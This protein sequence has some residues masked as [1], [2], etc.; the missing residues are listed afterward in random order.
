MKAVILVA[1]RGSRMQKATD[2]LPKC[3][4]PLL[5][6]P[7]LEWQLASLRAAGITET[8]GITGYRKER[9][10]SYF[11]IVFHNADWEKTNMLHTLLQADTLLEKEDV[12]ICYGDI[13]YHPDIICMLMKSPASLSITYDREWHALWKLRFDDVL[14]DAETFSE[15][16]GI[17]QKIGEKPECIKEI[18]GQYMG[19]IK[20]TP[21]GWSDLKPLI[22]E[23]ISFTAALK[24]LSESGAC[25][26]ALPISGKWCEVDSQKDLEQYEKQLL[27]PDRWSHDF[28]W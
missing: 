5:G 2:T 28:R 3:L 20:M 16:N 19:L 22:T 14:E 4:V 8:V 15:E 24:Q 18:K 13:V 12:L 7:L 26:Q 17:L 1:G 27:L 23:T 25:I 6:K 11:D 9:I 10:E 21:S